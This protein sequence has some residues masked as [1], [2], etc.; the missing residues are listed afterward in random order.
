LER[1]EQL[2]R[3]GMP[4]PEVRGRIVI[5]VDDGI[6][7]GTTMRSAIEALKKQQVT[8]VIVAVPVAP[9]S[10]GAELQPM[11]DHVFLTCLAT[12]EPFYAV[13]LWYDH[14]PQTSDEEVR[15]LLSRAK[16]EIAQPT[17]TKHNQTS[18]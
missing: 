8:S 7:T 10:F 9:E 1:R 2:Y 6:A 14:F 15:E 11:K 16:T 4:A 18:Y 13:G 3:G 5:L 12:P 17:I